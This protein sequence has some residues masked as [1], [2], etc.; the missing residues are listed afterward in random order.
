[1]NEY[2]QHHQETAIKKPNNK[3]QSELCFPY[4]Q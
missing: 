2:Y 4:E 1:M 3:T